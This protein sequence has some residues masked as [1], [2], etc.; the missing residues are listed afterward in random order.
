MRRYPKIA[1][2]RFVLNNISY[3][4]KGAIQEIPGVIEVRVLKKAFIASDP[5]LVQ[6]GVTKRRP[7]LRACKYRIA[8]VTFP[9]HKIRRSFWSVRFFRRDFHERAHEHAGGL[10]LSLLATA[11]QVE[12]LHLLEQADC[13]VLADVEQSLHIV[14]RKLDK[15]PYSQSVGH[16]G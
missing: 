9:A 2:N 15:K 4:G 7:G 8:F 11:N 14:E 6:A 12:F 3:H 5:G 1:V 13:L 10:V 16:T